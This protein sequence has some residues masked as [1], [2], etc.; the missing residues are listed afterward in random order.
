MGECTGCMACVDA[1]NHKAV[2][3]ESDTNGFL[4]PRIDKSKCVACHRC[5]IKCPVI[6]WN[7]VQLRKPKMNFAARIEDDNER[8][9]CT[10][11]GI[12]TALAKHFI[13]HGDIVYG[14]AFV[15]GS[16]VKHIRI[17]EL[18]QLELLKGSKYTQSKM[19]GVY[20]SIAKDLKDTKKEILFV[21]TPCQVASI[22]HYFKYSPRITTVSFICGGVMSHKMLC[23]YLNEKGVRYPDIKSIQFREKQTYLIKI[24][25]L[26]GDSFCESRKKSVYL[27]SFD[28]GFTIRKSCQ[29]CVFCRRERP[30]DITVGDYW[31][32]ENTNLSSSNKESMSC[33]LINSIKGLNL[34]NKLSNLFIEQST[35]DDIARYNHRIDKPRET[36]R[37]SFQ[38]TVFNILYHFL[39]FHKSVRA[40]I[41]ISRIFINRFTKRK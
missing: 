37:L 5:T 39:N 25:K 4:Y 15:K 27:K 26:N 14:A 30:G 11:G 32:I 38:I 13:M 29:T 6:N 22:N 9:N 10:S 20:S 18:N 34:A 36:A 40:T 33:L 12:C 7:L 16:G 28:A 21:G 31:G 17:S 41:L 1:C 3:L 19:C 24:C 8:K 2:T 35:I 23:D